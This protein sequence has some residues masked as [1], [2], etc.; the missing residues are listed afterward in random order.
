MNDSVSPTRGAMWPRALSLP[1]AALI[2]ALATLATLPALAMARRAARHSPR[3]ASAH[4]R[5]G[6]VPR[7]DTERA[8]LCL[9]NLQRTERGLPRLRESREL[10]RSAQRWTNTMVR[11]RAFSHGTDFGAR[12]SA[13]GFNWSQIGE[14]IADGYRTPSSVVRA[15]MRSRGHCENVLSPQFRE[16]GAGFAHGSAAGGHW[17]SG[18]WTL[19]FALQM[20]QRAPSGNWTPAEHCPY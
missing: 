8:T 15:W 20:G 5:L 16:A 12:I 2:L 3:C 11:E 1:A 7:A 14:N 9:L 18:T 6:R 10:V 17:R 19:D 13:A 4:A